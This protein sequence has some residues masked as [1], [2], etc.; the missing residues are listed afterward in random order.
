MSYFSDRLGLSGGPALLG[1]S[2]RAL[3]HRVAAV[4]SLAASQHTDT[5]ALHL[6][7]DTFAVVGD[8]GRDPDALELH[9][10]ALAAT[11]QAFLGRAFPTKY[12]HPLAGSGAVCTACSRLP[13]HSVHQGVAPMVPVMSAATADLLLRCAASLADEGIGPTSYSSVIGPD[14][15]P[16]DDALWTLAADI[17]GRE[18]ITHLDARDF[19]GIREGDGS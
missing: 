12:P 18:N 7:A 15:L 4:R 14:R 3:H 8:D 19:L 6:I 10:L 11:V 17:T 1:R 16:T 5:P 13:G 2:Y 9:V